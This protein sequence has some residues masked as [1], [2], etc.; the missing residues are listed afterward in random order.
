MS[1]YNIVITSSS[2]SNTT[3]DIVK[4]ALEKKGFTVDEISAVSPT[5]MKATIHQPDADGTSS[6][7][8]AI[9]RSLQL[10]ES[11]AT[12]TSVRIFVDPKKETSETEQTMSQLIGN[13]KV[14]VVG[15]G[16]IGCELLKDLF[17]A[18]WRDI[19]VIDMDTIDATN[20]NRQFLFRPEDVGKSKSAMAAERILSWSKVVDESSSSSSTSTHRRPP[21]SIVSHHGNVKDPK[22]NKEFYQQFSVVINGLDNVSAR[23]HVNRVCIDAGTPLVESGTMGYLG[24]AQPIV[25]GRYACYDCHPK[26]AEQKT[27]AV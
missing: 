12:T 5:M 25:R 24:Q 14:F 4:T 26:S 10:E 11:S 13:A 21:L 19:E 20:L 17:L 23:K 27:F 18:G 7:S 8:S 1:Q 3:T 9:P 6:S 22:F 16:G 2:S 15:A